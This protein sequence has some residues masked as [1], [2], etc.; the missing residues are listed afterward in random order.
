[1]GASF[2]ADI[3]GATQE[4][5]NKLMKLYFSA[6]PRVKLWLEKLSQRVEEEKLCRSLS[7]RRYR[8]KLDDADKRKAL[9]RYAQ[10]FAI[11]SLIADLVKRSLSALHENLADT[12]AK[13]IGVFQHGFIIECGVDD[14]EKINL[15]V[16]DLMEKKAVEYLSGVPINVT[17]IVGDFWEI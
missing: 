15:L 10:V 3:T 8:P 14:V 11:Q 12:S 17:L 4:N 2:L 6:Y 5:A 9:R 7:G 13:L 16:R 1:A